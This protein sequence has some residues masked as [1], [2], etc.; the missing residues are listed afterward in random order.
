MVAG[1][2]RQKTRH[3]RRHPGR[4]PAA[5]RGFR[6]SLT[7]LQRFQKIDQVLLLLRRQIHLQKAFLER[8]NTLSGSKSI[9]STIPFAPTRASRIC[10]ARSTWQ[11]ERRSTVQPLSTSAPMRQKFP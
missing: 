7:L 6:F 8:L 3:T 4:L 9:P 2:I 11:T 5:S 1:E 10:C